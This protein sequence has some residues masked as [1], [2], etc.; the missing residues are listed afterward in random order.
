MK[1]E[2]WVNF[3]EF[4][5]PLRKYRFRAIQEL[6]FSKGI[7]WIDSKREL[8][9]TMNRGEFAIAFNGD[10]VKRAGHIHY[11]M[12]GKYGKKID[13]KALVRKIKAL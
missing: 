3:D 8:Q 2:F 13:Y 1:E 11:I 6:L 5:P 12:Y 4:S 9:P 10:L 7:G